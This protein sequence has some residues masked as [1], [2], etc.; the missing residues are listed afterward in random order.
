MAIRNYLVHRCTVQRAVESR[1]TSG[2]V[3]N[4]FADHITHLP[5]RLI[6]SDERVASPQ[7][8]VVTTTYKLIVPANQDITTKDQVSEVVM[9]DL[10]T[11]TGPFL[12][13]AALPRLGRKAQNHTTL[14]V[15][16]IE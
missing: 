16:L 6:V 7:G 12:I 5:C 10:Q 15:E 3:V 13:L 2:E 4:T 1:G 8:F 11:T 14:R 9:E